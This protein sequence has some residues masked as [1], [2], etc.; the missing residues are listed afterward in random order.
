[1]AGNVQEF[2]DSNF[3]AD[4]LGSDIPVLVD[5]TAVWCAPCK[6]IAPTVAQ[7][8]DEYQGKIKVGKLDIDY[9]PKAPTSY[10]VRGVPT[11]MVFKGGKVA[12]QVM[13][14]VNKRRLQAMLDGAL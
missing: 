8:A 6:A 11:L 7:L 5:F 14:A 12:D 3:D 2:T 9:N 13:G 1:M 10:H 4:V